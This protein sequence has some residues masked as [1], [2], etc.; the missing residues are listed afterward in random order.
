MRN[1]NIF[2]N[3]IIFSLFFIF[4]V[5]GAQ[6]IYGE[7]GETDWPR[8]RGPNGDGISMETEWDPE[9]LKDGPKIVWE[10]NAG[11]G[12]S[13]V[14]IKGKYL[15]TVGKK[16]LKEV[17]IFC[18]NVETGKEVWQYAYKSD[19]EPRSMPT[20][21]GKYI[22]TLSFEG[23][24]FCI[25]A[26]NG[27]VRWQRDIVKEFGAVKPFYGY[28]GSPVIEGDLIILTTNMSGMALNKSTGEKVWASEI[29]ESGHGE[30]H[31]Q[32]EYATPVIYNYKGN[33]NAAIFSRGGLY[34]VDVETGKQRWSLDCISSFDHCIADPII[35]D[36]KVFISGQYFCELLDISKTPPK[37]LWKNDY[38]KNN[39]SSSVLLDGYIYGCDKQ[40]GVSGELTCIDIN[41]GKKMW[42][43]G[44]IISLIAADDKLITLSEKGRLAII[45]ATPSSYVEISSCKI[46]AESGFPK[47][48]THPVLC[49]G[50]IYCR[51]YTGD[52]VCID[53]S[54]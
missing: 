51:N 3:N 45:K 13:N 46:P 4:F 26:K 37:S 30:H 33:R 35:F 29:D 43:G 7:V 28:A 40:K 21:D 19:Y 9:A 1:K 54:K 11:M 27:K 10:T 8:W 41:T 14:S 38:M 15:Y 44:L 39:I 34:S 6:N 24:L 42:S 47:W 18:L 16:T 25:K 32:S 20:I 31:T 50:R 2:L 52:L 53:V 49:R 48:W 22:Y 12:Y 36:N 5:I 17:T 23:V